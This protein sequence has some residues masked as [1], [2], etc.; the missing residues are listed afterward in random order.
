MGR[1]PLNKLYAIML[2]VYACVKQAQ[3]RAYHERLRGIASPG[4]NSNLLIYG[5]ISCVFG[6]MIGY[7]D[8]YY[9]M[10]VH[11]SVVAL[12]VIG[13]LLYVMTII[14]VLSKRRA[15]F[16]ASDHGKIDILIQTEY[17]FLAIGAVQ[18]IGK[19][20]SFDLGYYGGF[21]EWILFIWSFYVFAVLSSIMP[22]DSCVVPTKEVEN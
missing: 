16:P 10:T 9:N 22:C 17:L 15:H 5:A 18:M 20:A 19:V 21:I 8:V 7:F 11:C 12:F 13:E 14:S 4:T 6:P 1:A 3:V 2:T